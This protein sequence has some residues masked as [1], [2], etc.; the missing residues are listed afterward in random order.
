MYVTVSGQHVCEDMCSLAGILAHML[1]RAVSL[2]DLEKWFFKPT[3]QKTEVH[4]ELIDL[5]YS[6]G[7]TWP[8]NVEGFSQC[9]TYKRSRLSS[10]TG[11]CPF[12]QSHGSSLTLFVAMLPVV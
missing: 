9:V 12:L 4:E 11:T 2:K 8:P 6:R 7:L 5:L 10:T 3:Y 1:G